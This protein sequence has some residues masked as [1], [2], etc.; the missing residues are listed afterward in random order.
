MVATW[1]VHGFEG[2][3]LFL[4]EGNFFFTDT[5]FYNRVC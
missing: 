1:M 2:W 4:L 3:Y 5:A